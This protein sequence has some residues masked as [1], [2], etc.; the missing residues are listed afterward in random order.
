MKNSTPEDKLKR[1]I[2][3]LLGISIIEFAVIPL[4]YHYY[5]DFVGVSGGFSNDEQQRPVFDSTSSI[6][7]IYIILYYSVY[8]TRNKVLAAII[9]ALSILP[10]II[11]PLG[12]L[13]PVIL[14]LY[15]AEFHVFMVA[16]MVLSIIKAWYAYQLWKVVKSLSPNGQ[17]T[18]VGPKATA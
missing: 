7:I 8:K 16:G 15:F 12:V 14:F 1:I 9:L 3:I 17:K 11:I 10:L 6:S 5:V 18:A 13:S 2:G 4:L